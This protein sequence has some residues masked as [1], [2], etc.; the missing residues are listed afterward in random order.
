MARAYGVSV[1]D[2]GTDTRE[3]LR[4]RI[5]RVRPNWW[6]ILAVTLA[7]IA[8]LVA[9]GT[10]P[11]APA[12]RPHGP[13]DAAAGDALAPAHG[14]NATSH[15]EHGTDPSSVTTTT[16][17]TVTTTARV[18]G[19]TTAT[20]PSAPAVGTGL[21]STTLPAVTTTT[22]G[23]TTT[24]TAPPGSVQP[25]D[26]TVGYLDPPAQTSHGYGFAGTGAMKVSVVWSGATYLTMVVSCPDG[27]QSVGGTSAM[28]ATL[29]DASGACMATV[30]EPASESV[31]L[32]YTISIG[33]SGA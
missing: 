9:T 16:V 26:R 21:P 4:H 3:D 2:G 22:V 20:L 25:S 28:V 5:P 6:V 15:G 23:A 1:A 30:T 13:T 29:P 8:L 7:L 14:G 33:P 19:H 31:A 12:H 27:G 24:T 10:A 18:A 32:T 11:R 17:S